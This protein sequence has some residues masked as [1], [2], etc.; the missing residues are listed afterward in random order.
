MF[1]D[2]MNQLHFSF[3]KQ[4]IQKYH[5][6]KKIHFESPLAKYIHS[7]CFEA[8]VVCPLFHLFN[9]FVDDFLKDIN[10]R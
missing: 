2:K 10:F 4:Q 1:C 7:T 6:N 9:D 8:N 5:L 3:Q